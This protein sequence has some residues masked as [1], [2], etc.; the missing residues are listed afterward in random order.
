[1]KIK[2]MNKM[3]IEKPK[4]PKGKPSRQT[5]ICCMYPIPGMGFS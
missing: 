3:K 1:M 4:S 2:K 5:M